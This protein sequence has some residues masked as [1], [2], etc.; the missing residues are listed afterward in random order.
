M[1]AP[2]RVG[3]AFLYVDHNFCSMADMV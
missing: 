1:L 2:V 3:P